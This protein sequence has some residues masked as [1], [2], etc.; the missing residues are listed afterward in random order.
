MAAAAGTGDGIT[1]AGTRECMCQAWHTDCV[2]AAAAVLLAFGSASPEDTLGGAKW[3]VEVSVGCRLAAN[4]SAGA[5]CNGFLALGQ[6]AELGTC[7]TSSHCPHAA[8]RKQGAAWE[9]NG[10][11]GGL[12]EHQG[13]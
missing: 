7:A 9:G 12:N 6:Q 13:V 8:Q 4:R 11:R 1:A 2:C 5:A 10:C 3:A